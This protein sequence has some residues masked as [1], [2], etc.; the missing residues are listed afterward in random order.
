MVFPQP[1]QIAGTSLVNY[2]WTDLAAGTGNKVYYGFCYKD[3]DGAKTYHLNENQFYSAE[4]ESNAAVSANGN[5]IDKDFDLLFNKPVTV[6]GNLWVECSTERHLDGATKS[7]VQI[8]VRKWDGATETE[9]AS[10]TSKAMSAGGAGSVDQDTLLIKINL[11]GTKFASGETL[12]VTALIVVEDYVAN[13]GYDVT[14]A[15]D[16][17]GRQG[18]YIQ[19][20]SDDSETTVFKVTVPF[21]IFA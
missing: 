20:A 13:G 17:T 18:T 19:P 7:Y 12:R 15:H 21:K 5:F 16:P 9:I 14:L 10:G 1:F 8:K 6:R 3:E 2:D 11:T 4:I